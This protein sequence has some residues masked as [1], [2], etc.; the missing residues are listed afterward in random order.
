LI[1][2]ETYI[3]GGEG[4]ETGGVGVPATLDAR[5]G[6]CLNPSGKKRGG[7]TKSLDLRGP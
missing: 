3:L 6:P 2:R 1:R 7:K 5:G 4:G